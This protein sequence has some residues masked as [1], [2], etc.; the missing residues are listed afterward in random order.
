MCFAPAVYVLAQKQ[1]KEE[2]FS[3]KIQT[4]QSHGSLR[5]SS[6]SSTLCSSGCFPVVVQHSP[7][8]AVS[9]IKTSA[10]VQTLCQSSVLHSQEDSLLALQGGAA[11]EGFTRPFSPQTLQTFIYL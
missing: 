2:R 8:E 6:A 1:E 5:V 4:P 11:Q 3:L 9:Q 7:S 10:E